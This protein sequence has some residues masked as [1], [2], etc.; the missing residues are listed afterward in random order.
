MPVDFG[1]ELAKASRIYLFRDAVPGAENRVIS[2][3]REIT[4]FV[5][6][7]YVCVHQLCRPVRIE[8]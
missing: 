4:R 5:L 1:K 8:N 6:L 7:N 2:F 3:C